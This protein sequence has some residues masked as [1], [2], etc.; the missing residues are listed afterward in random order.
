MERRFVGFVFVSRQ[1][2]LEKLGKEDFEPNLKEKERVRVG[3]TETSLDW[4]WISSEELKNKNS[5]LK[6]GGKSIS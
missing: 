3:R 1:M 4:I 6:L 2:S 5:A